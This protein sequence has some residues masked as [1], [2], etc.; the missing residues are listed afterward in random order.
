MIVILA[1]VVTSL[2]NE[3]VALTMIGAGSSAKAATEMK[4]NRLDIV[5][6]FD[7][8]DIATLSTHTRVLF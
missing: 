6:F 1:G 4:T 7:V 5:I 8:E 2:C 3:R